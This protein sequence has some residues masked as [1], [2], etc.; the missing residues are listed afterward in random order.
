MSD[1]VLTD[2]SLEHLDIAAH[3]SDLMNEEDGHPAS[4]NNKKSLERLIREPN[5][6]QVLLINL[7][8]K[9]IG[10][11]ALCAGFSIEY[12]GPDICLDEIY[13]EPEYRG[14]GY[15]LETLNLLADRVRE[16]G[17]VSFYLEVMAGNPAVKV[18]EKA[19][20]EDRNS[21]LMTMDLLRDK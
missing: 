12:G 14:K 11:V 4:P 7:D 10:Y 21:R 17:Y 19:G 18:Y 1:I 9:F 2:A 5:L 6:G 8:G 13:I 20:F 15:G 16:L 3:Y